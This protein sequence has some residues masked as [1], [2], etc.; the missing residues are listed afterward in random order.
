MVCAGVPVK[1]LLVVGY[2]GSWSLTGCGC[3]GGGSTAGHQDLFQERP[4]GK[5]VIK[6]GSIG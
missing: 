6:S 5:G 1:T 3:T 2:T 4:D